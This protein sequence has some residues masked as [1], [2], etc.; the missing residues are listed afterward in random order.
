[1]N[2]GQGVAHWFVARY[3]GGDEDMLGTIQDLFEVLVAKKTLVQFASDITKS[4]IGIQRD[5]GSKELSGK[6]TKKLAISKIS[7]VS[8]GD[9]HTYSGM[10][11]DRVIQSNDVVSTYDEVV[12]P[13]E[14][15]IKDG[16][17]S[18][19]VHD[20]PVIFSS[21]V[22]KV[23]ECFEEKS[24]E[25]K[26]L[27]SKDVIFV[28]EL[29]GSNYDIVQNKKPEIISCEKITSV[30]VVVNEM[31]KWKDL[32]KEGKFVNV[33]KP[34]IQSVS[35]NVAIKYTINDVK[36]TK[37][38][39]FSKVLRYFLDPG[40]R[41]HH[42]DIAHALALSLGVPYVSKTSETYHTE[43]KDMLAKKF[44]GVDRYAFSDAWVDVKDFDIDDLNSFIPV[45][46]GVDSIPFVMIKE[47]K[48]IVWG[49]VKRFH[50][51]CN[52]VRK[53]AKMLGLWIRMGMKPSVFSLLVLPIVSKSPLSPIFL[54][55]KANFSLWYEEHRIISYNKPSLLSNTD[56]DEEFDFEGMGKIDDDIMLDLGDRPDYLERDTKYVETKRSL[57]YK[58]NEDFSTSE[59]NDRKKIPKKSS[60][61]KE[62]EVPPRKK[63]V[64]NKDEGSGT[65][66][67]DGHDVKYDD[68][69]SLDLEN[70]ETEKSE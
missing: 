45:W 25:V 5:I 40:H 13:V 53:M 60:K 12:A 61:N 8:M 43:F 20:E 27:V 34:N 36:I 39:S 46:T 2:K 29:A 7:L 31:S 51:C 65:E 16:L 66:S 18:F 33:L 44:E 54:S 11:N 59:D 35:S 23:E 26:S 10:R 47:D 41:L 3:L 17:M 30:S 62:K 69:G 32:A 52:L 4:K 49:D 21:M 28:S 6:T 15:Q 14:T 9:Y 70:L 56:P 63:K 48:E 37:E 68:D 22:K 1:M 50:R 38:F 42:Q 19:I 55:L 67:E 57:R 58:E 64:K 24:I